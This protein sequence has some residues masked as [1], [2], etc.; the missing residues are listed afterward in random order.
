MTREILE[1][2]LQEPAQETVSVGNDVS[3]R[4]LE[5]IEVLRMSDLEKVQQVT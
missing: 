2:K 3:G 4:P 1:R 5:T